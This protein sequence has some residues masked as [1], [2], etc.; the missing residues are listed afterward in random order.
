[1]RRARLKRARFTYTSNRSVNSMRYLL[2]VSLLTLATVAHA[3]SD[4]KAATPQ[5]DSAQCRNGKKP[6]PILLKDSFKIKAVNGVSS[7]TARI[8]DFVEFKTM[9]PIYSNEGVPALIFDKD[10]PIYAVVTRRNH[11]HFPLVRGKLEIVLEP[12][13]TWDNQRIEMAIERHSKLS[14]AESG[15]T[16]QEELD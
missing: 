13:L 10:T 8:A 1:M 5:R 15:L 4:P 6:V 16:H 7:A 14:L 2:L 11:R 12:L 9:E 3:Q